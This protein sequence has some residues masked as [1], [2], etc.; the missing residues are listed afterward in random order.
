[1]HE[2][3]GHWFPVFPIVFFSLLIVF[4]IVRIVMFRRYG[5]SC[6]F[7]PYAGYRNG[8]AK[9]SEGNFD[10]ELILKK[11]LASG[12]IGVEEYKQLLEL[13]RLKDPNH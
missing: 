3:G 6:G 13:I 5:R 4:L 7:G 10:A 12:E 1:M 8:W 9:M 2:H 11:R